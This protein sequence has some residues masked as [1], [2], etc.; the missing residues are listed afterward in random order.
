[1]GCILQ[2]FR[3]GFS[4]DVSFQ[5]CL[6]SLCIHS[7]K[8]AKKIVSHRQNFDYQQVQA[9]AQFHALSKYANAELPLNVYAFKLVLLCS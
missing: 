4:D 1:M 9:A 5:K 6:K 3:V 7:H 2:Q 8:Y